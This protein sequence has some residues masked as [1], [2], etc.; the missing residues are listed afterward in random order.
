MLKSTQWVPGDWD[1]RERFPVFQNPTILIRACT[2][3]KKRNKL[4]SS[5]LFP[6][7]TVIVPAPSES[8]VDESKE[9]VCEEPLILDPQSFSPQSWPWLHA[10]DWHAKVSL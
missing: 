5:T 10:D 8:A 6:G 2:A 3:V 1:L 9:S 7:R 4:V